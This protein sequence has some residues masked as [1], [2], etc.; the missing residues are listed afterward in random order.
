MRYDEF[1]DRLKDALRETGLFSP[2]IDR[3]IE[4]IDLTDTIR[5]WKVFVWR[6][7]P[8]EAEPFHVSA[9]IAFRWSPFDAARSYTCEEDLLTELFGRRERSPKTETRLLRVDLALYAKLPYGSATP[10]PDP[11]IFG[12]WTTSIG[13]K[14]D[15]LLTE[16]KEHQGR[17]LAVMGSRQ[18]VDVEAQCTL[19]GVLSLKGV[20]LSG[21]RMARVPRV[22][23]DPKRREAEKGA[24]EE[25]DRLVPRFKGAL[26]A[27]AESVAELATWLRY[28][29]PPPGT[30]PLEDLRFEDEED[31]GGPE[32][33]H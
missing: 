11:Q 29:P 31:D 14:L 17:V 30:T 2:H 27:W 10:V 23:D 1:R 3:L 9:K 28:S 4:T 33:T 5:R 8:Q 32:P 26:D 16:T 25:L 24:A 18:D 20:S 22:W 6:S 15:K 21:F 19:E 7:I 13:E 12:P